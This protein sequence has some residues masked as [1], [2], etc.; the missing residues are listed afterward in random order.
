MSLSFAILICAALIMLHVDLNI[1][2]HTLNAPGVIDRSIWFGDTILVVLIIDFYLSRKAKLG[3]QVLAFEV[4]AV[5]QYHVVSTAF[6][7]FYGRRQESRCKTLSLNLRGN[8][9]HHNTLLVWDISIE[10]GE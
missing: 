8:S 6:C 1:Q 5:C 3:K 7:F 2:N 10:F 9:K 4:S